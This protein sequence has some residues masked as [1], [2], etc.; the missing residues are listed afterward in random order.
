MIRK[1]IIP[2]SNTAVAQVLQQFIY[3]EP[4]I[5]LYGNNV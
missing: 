1:I 4:K 3:L 2:A 5:T